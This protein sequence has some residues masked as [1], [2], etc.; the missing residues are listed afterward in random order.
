MLKNTNGVTGILAAWGFPA[1][2]LLRCLNLKNIRTAI[3]WLGSDYNSL[4]HKI[5]SPILRFILNGT[6]ENWANS[7]RMALGLN[8]QIDEEAFFVPLL[9]NHKMSIS[10]DSVVLGSIIC[11]SHFHNL[12]SFCADFTSSDT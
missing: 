9:T 4:D 2:L 12:P 11:S 1:G 7:H 10:S 5:F 8:K 6:N 3:W